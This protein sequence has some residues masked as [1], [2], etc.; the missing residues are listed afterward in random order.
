MI[1]K[2]IVCAHNS[3]HDVLLISSTPMITITSSII[4][5]LSC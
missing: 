3:N 2:V 1:L 5:F 4:P